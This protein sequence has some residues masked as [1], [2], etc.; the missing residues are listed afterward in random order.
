MFILKAD[1]WLMWEFVMVGQQK[2]TQRWCLQGGMLWLGLQCSFSWAGLA[3][4]GAIATLAAIEIT[5][6]AAQAAVLER[7]RFDPTRSQLEL[8]V[9]QGVVPQYS[10]LTQPTRVIVD[11]PAV[12]LDTNETEKIYSGPVH[13]VRIVQFQPDV[14]R[15]EIALLPGI[16]L[17]PQQVKLEKVGTD[18]AAGPRSLGCAIAECQGVGPAS[19]RSPLADWLR[20]LCN[21]HHC[22]CLGPE[23]IAC[24]A[25]AQDCLSSTCC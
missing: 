1:V 22:C 16:A 5:T 19:G 20:S 6:P 7:W 23:F 18:E 3:I 17:D 8:I 13:Q 2:L 11:L 4:A 9:E 21:Y 12:Q 25:A 15:I 10:L 14:A 24:G